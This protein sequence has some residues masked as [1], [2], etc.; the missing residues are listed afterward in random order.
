VDSLPDALTRQV[1]ERSAGNPLFGEEILSFLIDEGMLRIAA[2]KADFAGTA[3]TDALPASLQGLL[4]TRTGRLPPADRA[5][6]Q[7]AAT[8]G[9][10][11]DPTILALVVDG[12]D[13]IGIA[14]QR[15]QAQ[16]IVYRDADST[17]YVF[18]HVLLRDSVY[19]SLLTA[20]R[21]ELH[22]RVAQA[23]ERR[24]EGRLAEVAEA[25]AHHYGLTD[26][27]DAAFTYLAMAGAK[28]LGVFSLDE[29]DRYFAAA[30]A[31]YERAPRCVG[32]EQLAET[33]ARYALCSNISLR[34]TTMIDLAVRFAPHLRRLG[35]SHH[36][37]RFLHHY[38]A[39]LVWSARF[40]DAVRVQ[41]DLTAMAER[42]G[43]PQAAAFALVSEMSV[44]TYRNPAPVEV[45][46]ARRRQAEAALAAVDDA[47]LHNFYFA[48]LAWDQINRGRT[49]EARQ[50]VQRL[51]NVGAAMNDPRSLGYAASMSALLA[52]VS[53]NYEEG[54]EKAELG[55]SIARAP[56]EMIS[57]VTARNSALVLLRRPG[58]TEEVERHLARCEENGWTLFCAGPDSL[59]GIALAMDGRIAEGLRRIEEA[60]A[61]RE[62]EGYRAAADWARMFLCEVYLDILS[63]KGGA[64][65]GLL[66]RN[67]GALVRVF[68]LGP[69]RI[70]Q[71]IEQVR[72]NPQFDRDGHYIGR[73][74][75]IL[76]LL[77]KARK[78]K[79]RALRHLT[80]ARRILAAFGPSPTLTRVE[81]AVAELNGPR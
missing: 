21:A 40:D 31:L 36:H 39:S 11:F 78:K 62:A 6:L 42:L 61:R 53:D 38:A 75:M 28:S 19:Q 72:S 81:A 76:G 14:L 2:G 74:E 4:A 32:D 73:A 51:M 48:V 79:A 80:E 29:A 71:L 67:F 25:L 44:T 22:L 26:R 64:S 9:R 45:F 20:R 69:R 15:L 33:L 16:D 41:D 17:D 35:D 63:A 58:A 50:A 56:F 55:M 46:E 7:A 27:H 59:L 37:V 52:I 5:L 24:S 77:C 3:E 66:L 49:T 8:I 70:E 13:E 47:H 65:L 34:V 68:V 60:I 23:L 30:L 12:G 10:R 57:A 43:E 18:K 54:L 1:T